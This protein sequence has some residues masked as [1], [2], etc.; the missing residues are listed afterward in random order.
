[1]SSNG[2]MNPSDSQ[3]SPMDF[4]QALYPPVDGPVPPPHWV[5]RTALLFFRYMP[6]L[7]P[8]EIVW[9]D[10]VVTS[11]TQRP[12][13]TVQK[14]GISIS[15]TR[16]HIGSFSLRPASL[17]IRNLQPLVTQ[18]LLPGTKEAYGQL[19]LQDFNL[20]EQ[21][22]IMAYGQTPILTPGIPC[23]EVDSWV[24]NNSVQ[25]FATGVTGKDNHS[26]KRY[27]KENNAGAAVTCPSFCR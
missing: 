2:T 12:S 24:Q 8:R 20:L 17:P 26:K 6:S 5:S 19:L 1:M 14:V 16:L 10:S 21:Q 7:L 9:N 4:R 11:Q 27:F 23:W 13:L 18:T 25:F 22:T 15:L 3:Y